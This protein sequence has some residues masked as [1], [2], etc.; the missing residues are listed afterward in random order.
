MMNNVI[1]GI[2]DIKLKIKDNSYKNFKPNEFKDISQN[3]KQLIKSITKDN[4]DYDSRYA[5]AVKELTYLEE[6]LDTDENVDL[7]QYTLYMSLITDACNNVAH[8]CR[9][10][11]IRDEFFKIKSNGIEN[12]ESQIQENRNEMDIISGSYVDDTKLRG[13]GYVYVVDIPYVGQV[14]W[15]TDRDTSDKLEEMNIDPYPYKLEKEGRFVSE[16]LMSTA[17]MDR[18][19]MPHNYLIQMLPCGEENNLRAALDYYERNKRKIYDEKSR[20][21]IVKELVDERNFSPEMAENLKTVLQI[22][23]SEFS[24][25]KKSYIEE[26]EKVEIT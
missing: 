12:I 26:N 17:K 2:N 24:K 23:D 3:I 6:L 7:T 15:H 9:K 16:I 22:S 13:N 5:V 4:I 21:Q 18:K 1:K 19:N 8:D 14:S 20:L 10:T 11:T 25:A